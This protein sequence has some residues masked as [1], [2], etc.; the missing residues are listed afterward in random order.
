MVLTMVQ[1]QLTMVQILLQ[2]TL[3]SIIRVE[4]EEG[5]EPLSPSQTERLSREEISRRDPQLWRAVRELGGGV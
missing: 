2:Q 3:L 5:E 4:L 1:T